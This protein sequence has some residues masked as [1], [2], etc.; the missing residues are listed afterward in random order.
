MNRSEFE[1]AVRARLSDES[2]SFFRFLCLEETDSTNNSAAAE[3]AAGT[4][5]GLVVVAGKQTAGKGSRGRSFL[6]ASP[7]GLYF[8]VVLRPEKLPPPSAVKITAAAG[9]CVCNALERCGTP[10]AFI[11]WVNDVYMNGKKICGIL[12][13]GSFSADGRLQTVIC[14]IGINLAAPDG[15]FP[16]EIAATAGAAFA[17]ADEAERQRAAVLRRRSLL[18]GRTVTVTRQNGTAET[19]TVTDID[20]ECRLCVR[21]KATGLEETLIGGDVTLHGNRF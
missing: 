12:T 20:T 21:W 3:A 7:R 2:N 18:I 19:A 10:P 11:K 14:G 16:P 4:A 9:V 6:S 8:S 5:E 17:T 1:T 15:G 13:E